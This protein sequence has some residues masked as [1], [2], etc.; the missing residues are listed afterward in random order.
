MKLDEDLIKQLLKHCEKN[1][2][3]PRGFLFHPDIDGYA[4]EQVEYHVRLCSQA[5]FVLLNQT[6]HMIELT[7]Q[8]QMELLQR[9]TDKSS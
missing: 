8:G 1:S 7:W 9:Q 6:G 5:G 2:P 3:G 4:V